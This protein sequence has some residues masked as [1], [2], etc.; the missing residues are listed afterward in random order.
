MKRIFKYNLS[1]TDRQNI[2]VPKNS[3]ALSVGVQN[4][5]SKIWV[6]IDDQETELENLTVIIHGTGHNANDVK[7]AKF[8][9]TIMLCRESLVFHVFVQKKEDTV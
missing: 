5:E 9:G 7:N 4:G 2:I 1:I 3:Q 8:L 6:L